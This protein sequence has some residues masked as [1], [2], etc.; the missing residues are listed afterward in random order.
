[1]NKNLKFCENCKKEVEYTR[2]KE[3]IIYVIHGKSVIFK[4][5]VI[6]CKDCA[7]ELNDNEL[8]EVNSKLAREAYIK[9]YDIISSD[10][11]LH[12]L[13]L[14][15]ISPNVF[16]IILFNNNVT[17]KKLCS[18]KL[19]TKEESD[20]LKR[21][22]KNPALALELLKEQKEQLSEIEYT[23]CEQRISLLI[24]K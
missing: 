15:N 11:I 21:I 16:S 6:R 7:K 17:I 12:L 18:G 23:M 1:M 9:K 3:D 13:N 24:N 14:Y 4:N 5:E 20:K 10:D 2:K 8:F 22:V 19:P